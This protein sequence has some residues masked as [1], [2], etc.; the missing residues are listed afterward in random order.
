MISILPAVHVPGIDNIRADALSR[1]NTDFFLQIT[2]GVCPEMVVPQ[3]LLSI[4]VELEIDWLSQAWSR[5]GN[6]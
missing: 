6:L 5:L 1:S 3:E 4:I 2:P